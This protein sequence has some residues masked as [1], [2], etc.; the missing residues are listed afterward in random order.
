MRNIDEVAEGIFRLET[1][2]LTAQYP[3]VAYVIKDTA[4]AMIDPSPSANVPALLDAL[5]HLAIK[6]LDYILPT[7]LHMD[8]YGGTG[9][10][11]RLYPK[12]KVVV[13]PRYARH[14]IDPSR[15][16]EA[17][18]M[19][20]GSDFE[21]R[22]GTV[23]PV[24]EDVLLLPQDGEAI[25]VGDKEL[26][27]IYTPGHAPHHLAIYDRKA[28]GLFCGEA[29]GLP[30][31]QLPAAPPMSFDL[32]TYI[33]T[34]EK[35]RG[36]NLGAEMVF[37]SHGTVERESS[38]VMQRALDNISI[39]GDMVLYGL[40]NGDAPEKIERHI[41]TDIERRHGVR[42]AQRGLN[43]TVAGL[44]IYFKSKGIV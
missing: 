2:L 31:F 38:A 19:V 40:R 34:I 15:M 41:G 43:V 29:L 35:L 27:F 13:H 4:S 11:S 42:V 10:F 25:A 9:A 18:K 44:S 20:F 6:E 32:D 8:H 3:S 16:I 33:G 30:D 37:V 39:Y 7:H 12:A 14:A 21:E 24:A 17:F 1:P 23:E 28:R 26:E 5:R 36:M 22:F